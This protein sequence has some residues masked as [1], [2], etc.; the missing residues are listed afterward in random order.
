MHITNERRCIACRN[1]FLK[2]DLVRISKGEKGIIVNDTKKVNGRAVYL[3]KNP[4]CL[5]LCKKKR[6]LNRAFSQNVDEKV[7]EE[8][9]SLYN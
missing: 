2:K 7:Y 9:N 8:L 3:C 6:L 5:E 4:T 1:H